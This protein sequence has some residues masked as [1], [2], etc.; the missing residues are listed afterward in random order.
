MA[1]I[2]SRT[3]AFSPFQN[4][5]PHN[6]KKRLEKTSYLRRS[7]TVYGY[8]EKPG[9]FHGCRNYTLAN[10]P[11]KNAL[12]TANIKK[13]SR[14]CQRMIDVFFPA[15]GRESG[16]PSSA[17]PNGCAFGNKRTGR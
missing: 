1:S 12:T 16:A 6:N 14:K 5:T 17:T 13:L 9:A 10:M 2:P 15:Q 11:A 8:R 3:Q 4:K 7:L